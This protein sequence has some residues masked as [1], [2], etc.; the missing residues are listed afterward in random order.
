VAANVGIVP[1]TVTKE[2]W[3]LNTT[4]VTT[5]LPQIEVYCLTLRVEAPV[6]IYCLDNSLCQADSDGLISPIVKLK[7]K[8]F[9]VVGELIVAH[10]ITMAAA[11][12]NLKR[13][14]A[15]CGDRKVFYYTFPPLYQCRLVW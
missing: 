4:S 10:E 15:V 2:G 11:V 3:V 9:H 12:A 5:V 13:I 14:L 8:K 1:D 7:D 6:I